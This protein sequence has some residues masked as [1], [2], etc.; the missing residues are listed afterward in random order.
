MAHL[1]AD[2]LYEC[3]VAFEI[4]P[5]LDGSLRFP[6]DR[7]ALD[8][9]LVK[10]TLCHR[11]GW[12]TK[13]SPRFSLVAAQSA[14]CFRF[15]RAGRV[16]HHFR[17]IQTDRDDS[18]RAN[19]CAAPFP[20]TA[21]ERGAHHKF[22]VSH[23]VQVETIARIALCPRAPEQYQLVFMPLIPISVIEPAMKRDV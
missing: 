14:G 22:T 21:P 2:D 5:R 18:A 12:S 10:H 1:N 6:S 23:S 16:F 17:I 19:V 13:P 11:V 3:T 20:L 8:V 15:R 9:V 4:R 7:T